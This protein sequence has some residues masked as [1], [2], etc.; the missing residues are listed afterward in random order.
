MGR[1]DDA[2]LMEVVELSP[3]DSLLLWR[4]MA[5]TSSYETTTSGDAVKYAMVE[6]PETEGVG[7]GLLVLM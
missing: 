1:V 2:K 4:K 5:R 6:G 3:G 7:S